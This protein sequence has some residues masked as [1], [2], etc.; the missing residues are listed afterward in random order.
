MSEES[1]THF[2]TALKELLLGL[3]TWID[4]GI[5]H[6]EKKTGKETQEARPVTEEKEKE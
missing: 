4:S 1:K 2:R 6:L 3:R 5:Q